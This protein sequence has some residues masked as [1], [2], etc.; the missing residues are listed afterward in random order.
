MSKLK[1]AAVLVFALGLVWAA[2]NYRLVINGKPAS[3]PAIV[4]GGKTYVP[5]EALKAA[6][7]GVSVSGS[8][9]SLTLPGARQ[10][11]GGANQVAALEGCVNEWLFNG[12]WRFRVLSLEPLPAGGRGGWRAKVELRNGTT[13]NGAALAGTGWQGLMLVLDDGNTLESQ[14]VEM[15]DKPFAQGT[16]LVQEAVFY[17]DDTAKT[18]T[19]LLLLLDPKKMNTSLKIRYSV[20]DP[21]FR[22]RLDCRK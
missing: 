17:S 4:V 18:P 9:L 6:G 2:T 10:G 13:A 19:K 8:T 7:V 21:S 14:Y 11:Q 1:L 5:L 3:T 15:R 16:G 22:V 12:I 20:A